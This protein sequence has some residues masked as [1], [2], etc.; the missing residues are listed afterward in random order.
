MGN[1]Y[2]TSEEI[3]ISA[4]D[5]IKLKE[6]IEGFNKKYPHHC[7]ILEE[8]ENHVEISC[9]GKCCGH[10]SDV[11]KLCNDNIK[12]ISRITHRESP[13]EWSFNY[14]SKHNDKIILIQ[15]SHDLAF[16]DGECFNYKEENAYMN[17]NILDL[18]TEQIKLLMEIKILP[19]KDELFSVVCQYRNNDSA[20]K[21]YYAF[22][23]I[24]I[25]H[26]NDEPFRNACR[27][28]NYYFVRWLYS[29][30]NINIHFNQ[31]EAFRNS[32]SFNYDIHWNY[33]DINPE[34]VQWLYSL[35]DIDIHMNQDL[36]F[37]H[38]CKT[39][40]LEYV[41]WIYSLG[42][43]DIHVNRDEAFQNACKMTKSRY[44]SDIKYIGGN[45]E[46]AKWLYS[47][48]NV[49][50][51]ARIDLAFRNSFE[52]I[53][54]SRTNDNKLNIE[55]IKWLYSLGNIDIDEIYKII[56]KLQYTKFNS[57]HEEFIKT[58]VDLFDNCE[59]KDGKIIIKDIISCSK[60]NKSHEKDKCHLIS[61]SKCNKN[62]EKDKCPKLKCYN[63]DG[64]GHY[65]KNCSKYKQ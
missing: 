19:D 6:F 12:I 45:L 11:I 49:D 17:Y 27:T 43:V 34:L 62:H 21:L 53:E 30:G 18:T 40:N 29:M 41:K 54:Y 51:H 3:H 22:P 38:A 26:N 14:Y 60:C 63:C 8:H 44:G 56:K 42:N 16:R 58:F 2:W 1:L 36:A 57:R 35:G 33:I 28:G 64:I 39:G 15:T 37:R 13:G 61:C 47:L 59:Y 25:H 24:N 48:G 31:D 46:L 23:D 52:V 4:N 65:S 32:C 50:I 5:L 10:I 55:L 7:I 9:E 20:Y